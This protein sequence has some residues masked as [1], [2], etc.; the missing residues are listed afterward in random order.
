MWNYPKFSKK[1]KFFFFFFL[2]EAFTVGESRLAVFEEVRL[3]HNLFPFPEEKE[4]WYHIQ[5]GFLR[6]GKVVTLKINSEIFGVL[7]FAFHKKC[8]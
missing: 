2:C 4:Y 6:Q 1:E 5:Y 8:G 7:W 3:D